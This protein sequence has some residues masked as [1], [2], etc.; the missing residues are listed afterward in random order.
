MALLQSIRPSNALK[1]VPPEILIEIFALCTSSTDPLAN[2]NLA[3]V[4]TLWRAVVQSSPRIWQHLFLDDRCA[5][6]S[7]HAQAVLWTRKSYPLTFDVHLDISQSSGLVLPLLSPLLPLMNRW[8][9]FTMAGKREESIDLS[10]SL[11]NYIDPLR[12][13]IVDPD[14]ENPEEEEALPRLTFTSG[15]SAWRT[16]NVWTAELPKALSLVPLH[17][18]TIVMTEYSYTVLTQPR[19]ILEFLSACPQLETF[20]FTGWQHDD[21]KLTSPLPVARLPRLRNLHLRST[22]GTRSLLSSIDAPALAELHLS[23]LNV[24]FEYSVSEHL[25]EEGDSEDEAH[26]FSRSKWSDHATGMGLRRLLLRSSPPLRVLNMD[27]SDMRTKDFQ[28][29]FGRLGMLEHFF[30]EASDMSDKVVELLRP[31]APGR[32]EPVR[33]RLP[34]LKSIEL[35]NCNELSGGVLLDVLSERVRM[36][37]KLHAWEGNTLSEVII[38]DCAGFKVLHANMLRKELG[39]RLRV[40]DD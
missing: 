14:Q 11:P 24:D 9:H 34:R 31:Y 32:N 12:I 36:T 40:G 23:H 8:R 6:A 29:M 20:F 22:C 3:L 10:G 39:D 25:R 37:D 16:M 15:M 21:E 28:F 38:S 30:I 27:W 2:L 4:S 26:D 5:I 1:C 13:A 17:F 35:A 7:S 18:T 33:V 19:S